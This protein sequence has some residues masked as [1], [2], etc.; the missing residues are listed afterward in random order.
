[1]T[2]ALNS[3]TIK[4]QTHPNHRFQNLYGLLGDDLLYQSWGQLNKRAAPGIDGITMPKYQTSLVENVTRLSS[5]L[6]AKR[7]RADD[8]KRVFI[9]KS[10]GKQ[11]PLGLPT[12]D[13]KLVQQSVSQILQGIWEANFLPN[14]YGYRPNKSAH[15]AVHSLSLNLQFKGY[16]YIV[17]ADIKGF[18]DNI[19]HDWLMGMLKQRIDDNALLSLIG[20][21]LKARIHTPQ[22]EYLK[23]KSGT[24]QGGI[25]SPVLANIY[26]HYALDLWFEKKV[27]PQMRGRAM[28]IRY[29]DDFVCAF[30][31]ANDAERF[32]RVLPKRLKKFKLDTAPEKTSLIRF[33]RFH[34]SRKRQFVFLGFAFYW[35]VDVKGK[36]RLRRR[37]ASKKQQTSLSEFYH[38]IKAKRSQKLAIWLPQLKRKLTGFRNYFGLP[39]NSRSVSKLYNYVLHSLYKWLN[40]RS[41]RRSY[42]WRDFKKMLE[43]FQIQKLRVSKRVI[44]VDWY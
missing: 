19:D 43:Y 14:S 4:S 7:Y 27:K 9:P 37:T 29:A 44:D 6:E 24:P 38:F 11:R 22:G 12:V 31:Y 18:F 35:G 20:Q 23:P 3:I 15:Q 5:A 42:N 25:I 26:L 1:M 33:S 21:W 8:I 17:E 16:G 32:Y 10:H 2:T 40:R 30:Q 13:D 39:D 34:P 28:L 41:G 36:P